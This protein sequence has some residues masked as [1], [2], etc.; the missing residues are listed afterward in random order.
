[1]AGPPEFFCFPSENGGVGASAFRSRCAWCVGRGAVQ[2][3]GALRIVSHNY[4]IMLHCLQ[5][6]RLL[7]VT[8]RPR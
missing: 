4:I 7:Q 5:V 2:G 8:A 3:V 1:M 6:P